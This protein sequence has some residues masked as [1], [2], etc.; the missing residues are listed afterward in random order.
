MEAKMPKN[1]LLYGFFDDHTSDVRKYLD[2][3][4]RIKVWLGKKS[5][6]LTTLA[7]H[8][9]DFNHSLP[10]QKNRLKIHYRYRREFSEIY[11]EVR[12]HAD[13][14]LYIYCRKP[15][16]YGGND[17]IDMMDAFHV[18]IHF[19]ID[20]LKSND[21]EGVFFPLIPHEADYILYL[22]AKA[23]GIKAYMFY[24]APFPGKSFLTDDIE[25]IGSLHTG[26][27]E[28]EP[29]KVKKN[30]RKHY[31]Y[32][33]RKV[34]INHLRK[35]IS[36]V[37][38]RRDLNLSLYRLQ[39]LARNERFKRNYRQF[40]GEPPTSERFVYFALHLQ[41]ELTT[42]SL[43]GVFVDQMLA[44]ECLRALLPDDRC[45]VVKENPHQTCHSRGRLFYA[46]LEKIPK[47]V[48]VGKE[49]DTYDLIERSEFVAT[50]T[51]NVGLDA[52][53]FGKRV[54][55]FG[56]APYKGFP[57]VVSYHQRLTFADIMKV[58]FTHEQF[59]RACSILHHNTV[60]VVTDIDYTRQVKDF[61]NE[62]NGRALA[63]V[64]N[65]VMR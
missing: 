2:D 20:L 45:I 63:E 1:I 29:I 18:Y 54:L 10:F 44:L 33:D 35:L 15:V 57:G 43:G 59:E 9:H 65:A 51:G 22:V 24:P 58:R 56:N 28:I 12:K 8:I 3:D 30:H 64:I 48:Y 46:R 23:L 6:K 37:L 60:D 21:I 11:P 16:L 49:T 40:T 13:S 7:P 5:N 53:R 62:K 19:Y 47:L 42:T 39:A 31:P 41:P 36:A 38:F 4:V 27:A 52:L 50:I 17:F 55:I 61:S 32:M 14:F 26:N 25:N 34:R